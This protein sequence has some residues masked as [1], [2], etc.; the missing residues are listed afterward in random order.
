MQK[1]DAITEK[2]G[3][4]EV[5]VAARTRPGRA[6]SKGKNYSDKVSNTK[7]ISHEAAFSSLAS[8]SALSTLSAMSQAD[9][10]AVAKSASTSST[11]A[12]AEPKRR[13]SRKQPKRAV[14]K[15][16][17]ASAVSKAKGTKRK[18]P[19]LKDNVSNDDEEETVQR[20]EAD[21]EEAEEAEEDEEEVTESDED[22]ANLK[23]G[24]WTQKQLRALAKS[25]LN[26]DPR[27]KR[28]WT[29]VAAGVPGKTAAE[30]QAQH[31]QRFPSPAVRSKTKSKSVAVKKAEDSKE[32]VE[33]GFAKPLPPAQRKRMFKQMLEDYDNDYGEDDG[34]DDSFDERRLSFL[35][36]SEAEKDSESPNQKSEKPK[37]KTST[38]SSSSSSDVT[39]EDDGHDVYSN[40]MDRNDADMYINRIRKQVRSSRYQSKRAKR[41][42][43]ILRPYNV[44]LAEDESASQ[45]ADNDLN[46]GELSADSENTDDRFS[47]Y[48]GDSDVAEW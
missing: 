28:F 12:A 18:N 40:V 27:C 46:N 7:V 39:E 45:G 10:Q 48:E 25:H 16:A 17:P 44:G 47:E 13:G 32:G 4:A 42:G 15:S 3:A 38:T 31:E 43:T 36:Q 5:V 37:E 26:V 21:E 22:P 24:K 30:C 23:P 2:A 9:K 33:E 41:N 6:A 34:F 8:L 29:K 14:A 11:T 1:G 35:D 19:D 20:E